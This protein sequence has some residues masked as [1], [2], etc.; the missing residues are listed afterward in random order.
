M[1][2]I[3]VLCAVCLSVSSAFATP[4]AGPPPQVPQ[5]QGVSPGSPVE[6]VAIAT[7]SQKSKP[8]GGSTTARRR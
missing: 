3:A 4:L 1:K 6:R 5:A 8:K 2:P 7:G